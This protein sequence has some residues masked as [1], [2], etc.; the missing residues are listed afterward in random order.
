MDEATLSEL[1]KQL[2]TLAR[3]AGLIW[4]IRAGTVASC[5]ET[6]VHVRMSDGDSVSIPVTLTSGAMLQ[7]SRVWVIGLPGEGGN[8]VL[9]CVND[10]RR[11]FSVM[12]N[13]DTNLTPLTASPQA[14]SG[15]DIAVTVPDCNYVVRGVFDVSVSG[16]GSTVV[17]GALLVDGAEYTHPDLGIAVNATRGVS[18]VGER[19]THPQQWSGEL[20]AGSHTFQ[21]AAYRSAAAG[22]QSVVRAHTSIHLELFA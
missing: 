13:C 4:T 1:I 7:D 22:T 5:D 2:P 8:Y 3:R 12:Q 19:G 20:S 21:L 15:T 10:P 18:A 17:L 6:E 11:L 9:G 14:V 16:A